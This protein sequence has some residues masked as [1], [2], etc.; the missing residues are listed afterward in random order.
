MEQIMIPHSRAAKL[1]SILDEV[2]NAVG[3]EINITDSN[4]IVINGSSF[5]EY[6]A[7]NVILAFGR[8]F[9]INK[10]YKLLLE[11]YFFKYISLRDVLR[12][13]AQIKRI[14]ARIIGTDGKT[15]EYIEE[16][17]GAY[18][19]VYGDT[20]GII[21]KIDEITM[22]TSALQVLI[23]GGTHKKAYRVMEAARRKL[24]EV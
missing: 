8:G 10:A 12:N 24:R 4:T 19:S 14:K 20:I 22:A 2:R 18:L 16:V 7:K 23:E 6:N 3:C 21:G 11:D 5:G 17:S 13:D 1:A 9:D 15:K